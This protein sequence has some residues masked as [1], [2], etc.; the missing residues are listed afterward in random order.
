VSRRSSR[1]KTFRC[2]A[3]VSS[4]RWRCVK[5]TGGSYALRIRSAAPLPG[6]G[7]YHLVTTLESK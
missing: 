6:S 4:T 3:V 1:R 2:H 7:R 5:T